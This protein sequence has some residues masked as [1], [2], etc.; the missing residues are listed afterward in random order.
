MFLRIDF[1]VETNIL[2]VGVN[3]VFGRVSY[4]NNNIDV[5]FLLILY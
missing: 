5:D 3:G 4:R 1:A 2:V